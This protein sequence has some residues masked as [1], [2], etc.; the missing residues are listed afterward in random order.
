[1]CSKTKHCSLTHMH[2][3]ICKQAFAIVHS[4]ILLLSSIQSK[5]VQV[6]S[7]W[8]EIQQLQEDFKENLVSR[9]SHRVVLMLCI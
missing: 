5:R 2:E 1:M 9:A 8:G 4:C 6:M 3:G 7:M